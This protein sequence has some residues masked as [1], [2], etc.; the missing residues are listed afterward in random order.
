[1]WG[2]I[3]IY[4]LCT[5]GRRSGCDRA[6]LDLGRKEGD[7]GQGRTWGKAQLD[8]RIRNAQLSLVFFFRLRGSLSRNHGC[9]CT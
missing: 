5:I 1:M 2:D 4:V 6:G 9:I 7:R 3:Y 8:T